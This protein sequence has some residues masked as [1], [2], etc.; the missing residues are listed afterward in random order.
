[1]R[2]KLALLLLMKLSG[3]LLHKAEAQSS[4]SFEHYYT[5]GSGTPMT[6]MPIA[7]YQAGN[8]FYAEGRYNYEELNTFSFYMGK[9]YAKEAPFSYSISPIAGAVMGGFNGGS[10]GVNISLA[11]KNFYLYAQPQYSFS[12]ENSINNFIYSWTDITYSPLNWLSIGVSLQHTKP[13]KSSGYFE[14]GLVIEAAYKKLTFP[15]YIFNPQ[16]ENRSIVLGANFELN[17][18]KKKK[19]SEPASSDP[20]KESYPINIIAQASEKKVPTVPEAIAPEEKIVKIRRVNVVVVNKQDA[21]VE[22]AN[23]GKK[24]LSN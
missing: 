16:S 19:K 23:P 24:H 7:S 6:V 9:T 14:N 22:L 10:L 2:K 8:G 12:L 15:V 1:M 3:L 17:F 13:Y 11:Y 20:F 5:M 21:E 18:R 4:L